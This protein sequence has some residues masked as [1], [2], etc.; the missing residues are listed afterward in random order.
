MNTEIARFSDRA[1]VQAFWAPSLPY[2][3]P[4]ARTPKFDQNLP[5]P[6][7]ITESK[8]QSPRARKAY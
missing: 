2:L 4:G 5:F 7:L 8:W 1:I 6:P 3:G